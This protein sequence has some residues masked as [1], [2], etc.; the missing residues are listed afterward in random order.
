[1]YIICACGRITDV[2]DILQV[3]WFISYVGIYMYV[4]TFCLI[5]MLLELRLILLITTCHSHWKQHFYY[6]VIYGFQISFS[7]KKLWQGYFILN[8]YCIICHSLQK[9]KLLHC[10]LHVSADL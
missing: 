5:D 10:H 9:W 8:C 2:I 1:M 6:L 7:G 3:N 4:K